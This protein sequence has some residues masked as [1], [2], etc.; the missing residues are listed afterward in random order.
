LR[1]AQLSTPSVVGVVSG[2]KGARRTSRSRVFRLAARPMLWPRRAPAAPPSA[3]PMAVCR[4][5]SRAVLRAQGAAT[6]GRRSVKMWRL[7]L[8]LSQKSFRMRRWT[9]TA[10]SYQ[11][12]VRLA[13]RLQSGHGAGRERE[14][15]VIVGGA[16]SVPQVSS[17]TTAG[18]GSKQ[19]IR[20]THPTWRRRH[21]HQNLCGRP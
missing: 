3:T 6:P 9:A 21:D 8:A 13:R 20:F 12:W 14:V 11:L 19:E 15:R 7:H 4:S 2:G 1:S 5:D 17:R 18:S 10:R 16:C